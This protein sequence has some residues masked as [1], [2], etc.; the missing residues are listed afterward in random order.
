MSLDVPLGPTDIQI[1]ISARHVP[2]VSQLLAGSEIIDE[3]VGGGVQFLTDAFFFLFPFNV[4]F[5]LY[6]VVIFMVSY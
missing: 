3:S 6:D 5:L 2:Q 4:H 1:D